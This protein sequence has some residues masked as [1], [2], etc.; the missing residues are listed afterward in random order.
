MFTEHQS[1]AECVT[2]D[3]AKLRGDVSVRLGTLFRTASHRS[4]ESIAHP[5]TVGLPARRPRH[6]PENT[7]HN[8]RH[9]GANKACEVERSP[10][11]ARSVCEAGRVRSGATK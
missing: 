9:L 10:H 1:V 6:G 8:H 2:R 7:R 5:P 11:S 4:D 3:C